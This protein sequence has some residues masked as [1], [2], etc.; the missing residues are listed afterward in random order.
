MKS[1]LAAL[2]SMTLITAAHAQGLTGQDVSFMEFQAVD[3]SAVCAQV[4]TT[5]AESLA[6]L[7]RFAAFEAI[8]NARGAADKARQIVECIDASGQLQ[9]PGNYGAAES[10]TRG[11][12]PPVRQKRSIEEILHGARAPAAP[13]HAL[14]KGAGFARLGARDAVARRARLGPSAGSAGGGRR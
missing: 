11:A 1:T 3:P 9:D 14:F 12:A 8:N 5:D 13:R 2:L 10:A 6:N 7:R 4:A